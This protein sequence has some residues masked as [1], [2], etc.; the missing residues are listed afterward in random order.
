M[1]ADRSP[2]GLACARW[3]GKNLDRE[4]ARNRA[5]GARVKA[6]TLA[7]YGDCCACCGSIDRLCLDHVNGDG[8]RHREE[9]FGARDRADRHF[10]AWLVREGFPSDPPMQVL[11]HPCSTSKSNGTAC[12]ID[13]GT[14]LE[15]T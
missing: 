4:R 13:H 7:H 9:L 10:Y 6:Q 3:R 11:C 15:A 8:R 2:N 14:E 1:S 12:R 5:Y